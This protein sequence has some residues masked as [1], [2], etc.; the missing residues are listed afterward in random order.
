MSEST[1]LGTPLT[2]YDVDDFE[3]NAK[4]K[5]ARSYLES[6]ELRHK[7]NREYI[8]RN[9]IRTLYTVDTEEGWTPSDFKSSRTKRASYNFQT[10]N[11][12][13]D[14]DDSDII[15]LKVLNNLNLKQREIEI[16]RIIKLI[17][18]NEG[19]LK[20]VIGPQLPPTDN[21]LTDPRDPSDLRGIGFKDVV[22]EEIEAELSAMEES[23]YHS[24][25]DTGK[26]KE[27]TSKHK[28]PKAGVKS[29]KRG[30]RLKWISHDKDKEIFPKIVM[31]LGVKKEHFKKYHEFDRDLDL[32]EIKQCYK[33]YYDYIVKP[34]ENIREE[35]VED[36]LEKYT[37]M[38]E[39]TKS[40][41]SY[42]TLGADSLQYEDSK[43]AKLQTEKYRDNFKGR[44]VS[45]YEYS[46]ELLNKFKIKP[47]FRESEP[48]VKAKPMEE[49]QGEAKHL[50]ELPNE[51]FANIFGTLNK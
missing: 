43:S 47:Q 42:T 2:K 45:K 24:D 29:R 30:S 37:K 10:L 46:K 23:K 40:E 49:S 38:P 32:N 11:K 4:S 9:K 44:T 1:F 12:F 5:R 18:N 14:Q 36:L 16:G 20:T 7:Q 31:D 25:G 21:K 35:T 17:L 26:E 13:T 48:F 50:V 6:K 27:S 39:F 15:S 3:I 8:N 22:K 33:S 41:A 51:I 28:D 19:F 34:L